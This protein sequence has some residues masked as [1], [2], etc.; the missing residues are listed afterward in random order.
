MW[1]RGMHML[2][3]NK[4]IGYLIYSL[5]CVVSDMKPFLLVLSFAIIGF[6]F[7]FYNMSRSL[8]LD[9]NNT[10]LS[11]Y[12]RTPLDA[13]KFSYLAAIDGVDTD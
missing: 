3:V 13:L 10:G 4:T 8:E 7:T 6:A 1:A 11:P 5:D 9:I 2:K 12:L